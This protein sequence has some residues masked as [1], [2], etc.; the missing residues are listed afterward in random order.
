M[1]R[2]NGV[3][4]CIETFGDDT[5]PAILLI[6]GAASSM[7]WWEDEFCERLVSGRRFVVRYDLRDTGRS[8]NYQAGAPR[9][10]G[11]DLVSDAVGLLDALEIERAH[12]VGISMGGGIAQRLAR[13]HAGRVASLTLMSTSSGGSDL[14]PMSDELASAFADPSPPPDWSDRAAVIDHVVDDLRLYEGSLPFDEAGSRTLVARIVDR[15]HDIEASMTN[16]WILEDGEPAR[17]RLGEITAPTLVLHGTEDPLFPIGHAEAL[18]AEIPG[19]RLLPL[20]GMGHQM[21]PRS[22]WDQ[23]VG[24]ILEH[25]GQAE[26]R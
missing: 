1:V 6:G 8:V 9:Y 23:V 24:A 10:S 16:H 26:A 12:V 19:A 4:L 25:T 14:P 3:D 22:R 18:A 21:P 11:A 17:A 7:D 20:E 2:A 13:A 15:T 5:S